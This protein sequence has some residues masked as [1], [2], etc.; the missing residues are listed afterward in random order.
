MQIFMIQM[1]LF[2]LLLIEIFKHKPCLKSLRMD[3]FYTAHFLEAL[4]KLGILQLSAENF[5]GCS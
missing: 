4:K 5:N 2:K 1:C 3:S